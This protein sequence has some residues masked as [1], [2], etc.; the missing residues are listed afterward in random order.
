MFYSQNSIIC[1][2]IFDVDTIFYHFFTSWN[3]FF[4]E[5]PK[6]FSIIFDGDDKLRLVSPTATIN[7]TNKDVEPLD[8][9]KTLWQA[10]HSTKFPFTSTTDLQRKQQCF[11]S[12]VENKTKL[13]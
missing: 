9:E 3:L 7:S 6:Y 13:S 4:K 1:Y 12:S 5:Q 2:T 10:E 11:T 8:D